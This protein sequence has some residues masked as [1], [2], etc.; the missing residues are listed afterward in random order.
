[1]EADVLPA[2][3]AIGSDYVAA[4]RLE[5]STWNGSQPFLRSQ[6]RFRCAQH[7][8]ADRRP[9]SCQQTNSKCIC[10]GDL[11]CLPL[12]QDV[13]IFTPRFD[14]DGTLRSPL[15]H[16]ASCTCTASHT[17]PCS[18]S[19]YKGPFLPTK[20]SASPAP[21]PVYMILSHQACPTL[22]HDLPLVH[23]PSAPPYAASHCAPLPPAFTHRP[24]R[25]RAAAAV[26]QPG[27]ELPPV[28]CRPH[29][30]HH[31][32]RPHCRT[33]PIPTAVLA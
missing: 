28:R 23:S 15:P 30:T 16:A 4:R 13:I 21:H 1:M 9:T 19:R 22:H 26:Q 18:P 10:N 12:Y 31:R 33:P 5:A 7:S 6:F 24:W 29:R 8:K 11:T 3:R 17:V 14:A 20:C 25:R 32:T 27:W 2:A